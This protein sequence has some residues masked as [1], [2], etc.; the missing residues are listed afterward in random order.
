[1]I[2]VDQLHYYFA[3]GSNMN[4]ARVTE[5]GLT[6]TNVFAATL[7]NAALCF[8]KQAVKDPTLAYANVI[9]AK[10]GSVEGVVY[11][12]SDA[13]QILKMDPFEGAPVRYSRE[14]FWLRTPSNKR[15][16]A[17][18]YIANEAMLNDNLRPARWY[19]DHLLQGEPYLSSD[20]FQQLLKTPTAD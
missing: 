16:A 1:M 8:N 13:E 15:V 5:R 20:Y 11:Q 17:W 18:V 14:M 6:Y 19:L 9:Y 4:A 7:D 2:E 3:Y 10:Q 12:L